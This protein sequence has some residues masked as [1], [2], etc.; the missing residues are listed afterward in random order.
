MKKVVVPILVA[1]ILGLSFVMVAN[2]ASN[3][4]ISI[5]NKGHISVTGFAKQDITSDLGIFEATIIAEDPDLKTC[6]AELAAGKEK[7]EKYLHNNFNIAKDELIIEP[8][9]IRE[10]YKVNERGHRTDELSRYNLR[11]NVKV[12]SRDVDKIAKISQDVVSLLDKGVKISISDPKYVYTKLEDLKIEMIGRATDN[13]RERAGIIAKEGRFRLGPIA[14]VRVGVFQITPKHSTRISSYG[15]NDTSS[16]EKEIKSV[17]H[18]R[19]FVR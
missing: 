13:A 19:Y 1:L 14:D 9:A 8:A 3:T 5:K 2:I 15:I 6:Y 17:V 12:E 4:A 10:I 7:L 16:I 18:I 11:Q